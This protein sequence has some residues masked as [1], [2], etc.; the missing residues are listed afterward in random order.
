MVAVFFAMAETPFSA[1]QALFEKEVKA[2][3]TLRAFLS[4]LSKYRTNAA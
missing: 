1:I 4:N 3:V 2:Q